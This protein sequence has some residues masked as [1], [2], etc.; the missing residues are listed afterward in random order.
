MYQ[1][2]DVTRVRRIQDALECCGFRS[3]RDKAWPF[4]SKEHAVDECVRAYG[5]TKSCG[6]VW[7]RERRMVLGV[8]VGIAVGGLVLK[9]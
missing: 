8:M 5:R 4:P 7:G 1:T 9:V 6:G 2:K 3:V